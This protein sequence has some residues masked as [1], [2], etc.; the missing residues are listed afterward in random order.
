MFHPFGEIVSEAL[1]ENGIVLLRNVQPLCKK[2]WQKILF[3]VTGIILIYVF[4]AIINHDWSFIAPL[5]DIP[6]ISF[7]TYI[8][9]MNGSNAPVF[10]YVVQLFLCISFGYILTW[11]V[12]KVFVESSD[13][14]LLSCEGVLQWLFGIYLLALVSIPSARISEWI[15]YH[16]FGKAPLLENMIL[17]LSIWVVVFTFALLPRDVLDNYLP[18]ISS[19][20]L[21]DVFN[22]LRLEY[23][24][25]FLFTAVD[26]IF[27]TSFFDDITWISLAFIFICQIIHEKVSR[28]AVYEKI[29]NALVV[30]H[31]SPAGLLLIIFT[32]FGNLESAALGML[33]KCIKAMRA[34]LVA[35]S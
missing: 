6:F 16:Q 25:A 3:Y 31:T 9:E 14:K 15:A 17:A 24:F 27:H 28:T 29:I 22:F 1:K 4:C 10:T 30:I 8:V 18:L 5:A 13:I 7:R 2:K 32:P 34:V 12:E 21:F 19:M 26:H 33:M 35:W 11:F 20:V 23:V